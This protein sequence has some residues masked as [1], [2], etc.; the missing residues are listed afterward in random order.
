R[1]HSIEFPVLKDLN[2][3]LA[4][5]L[6]ATRTPEV[7]VLD[8]ERTIRYAG[9][10][11][12]QY[13][14][15]YQRKEPKRQDLRL[16]LE[17]L[18]AGKQVSHDLTD[19]VGCHIGRTHQAV[20]DNSV[21]YSKQIAR[22]L[23]DRCVSCHRPG[24]IAPFALTSYDEVSG[25]AETIDEVV[26]ER[27]MPPWHA[28]PQ[29]GHFANDARLSDE[30]LELIS[31]WVANGAPQGDPSD[32]PPPRQFVE[33]WQVPREPDRVIYMTDEP[34]DVPAEGEVKYRHF[35]VDPGFTEDKWLQIA[36]CRPG[37]RAVV[38]HIVVFLK[39]PEDSPRQREPNFLVGFAPGTRPLV[40]SEGTAK[41]IPA[42]S[43]LVFQMHYTPNGSPQQDRS[44]V[45]LIF[46]DPK[47]IT[48]RAF[49][50]AAAN[51]GFAIPPQA[52][53]HLVESSQTAPADMVLL[54]M[55]PHMHL[56]G[57]SFRYEATY[58]D[59]TT[60]VLLD[61]PRYDFGWQNHFV[62]AEPKRVPKGTKFRCFAHFDNSDGNPAN[63]D[64]SATVRW[65]D[66]TWEEMMIGYLDVAVP[67]DTTK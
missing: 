28:D 49:T 9:R 22:I 19:V 64:P 48:H 6:G 51:R 11:D 16:A 34:V 18:L 59:G 7:F 47:T 1:L 45:G 23:Q 46:A 56:R 33:G 53:N 41:R 30:E 29:Y 4:D 65:G 35:T 2:H 8:S 63:P 67:A 42:G 3:T 27:R 66:Q 60:E 14:I 52:S 50:T 5:A 61:V 36:E 37:N 25:W 32:L 44:C 24:Q 55:F 39:S 43:K 58:P 21:T 10:I 62:L 20:T 38:H 31:T 15:G 40:F 54:S 17:E 57:K 12:D 26:K 13:G